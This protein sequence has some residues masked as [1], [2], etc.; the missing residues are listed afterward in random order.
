[1]FVPIFNWLDSDD[2]NRKLCGFEKKEM[3]LPARAAG[4]RYV[5][6]NIICGAAK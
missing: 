3:H 1:M 4:Y 5:Y 6:N 2:G